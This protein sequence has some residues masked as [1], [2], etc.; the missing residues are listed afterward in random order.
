MYGTVSAGFDAAEGESDCT[1]GKCPL[2][3]VVGDYL[4]ECKL[5]PACYGWM[6]SVLRTLANGRIALILEVRQ[7]HLAWAELT[8]DGMC[9]VDTIFS[10]QHSVQSLV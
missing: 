4:G 6:T 5:T 3:R 8:R 10:R 2:T 7:P 1:V 9:R